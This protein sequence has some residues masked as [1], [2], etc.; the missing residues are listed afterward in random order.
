MF[1]A[2]SSLVRLFDVRSIPLII[3][4]NLLLGLGGGIVMPAIFGVQAD[5]ILYIKQKTGK[6]AEAALGSLSAYLAKIGQGIAGALPG[7]ILAW[8]GFVA[9]APTQSDTVINGMIICVVWLPFIFLALSAAV[10]AIWY[11]ISKKEA[12]KLSADAK[13]EN[14]QLAAEIH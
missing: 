4:S 2:A 9:N 5:N 8:T 1:C 14:E 13:A 7:Y 10:F 11:N 6:R 12:D 3:V